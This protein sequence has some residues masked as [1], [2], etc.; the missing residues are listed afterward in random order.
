M[1][2]H[3]SQSYT[4]NLTLST[5]TGGRVQTSSGKL[6]LK[7]PYYRMSQA[8]SYG[9]WYGADD[10]QGGAQQQQQ[11][12]QEAPPAQVA[13]DVAMPQHL[14]MAQQE[15]GQLTWSRRFACG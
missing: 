7:E 13:P 9:A 1:V 14:G 3:S 4:I 2:A 12:V 15:V 8:A 10:Q 5:T 6:D 11:P